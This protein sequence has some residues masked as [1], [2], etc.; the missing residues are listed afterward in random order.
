MRRQANV[1]ARV[2]A[3]YDFPVM[4]NGICGVLT[5]LNIFLVDQW[6]VLLYCPFGLREDEVDLV[7]GRKTLFSSRISSDGRADGQKNGGRRAPK[8]WHRDA[9]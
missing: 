3:F 5:N 2:Q 9:P 7:V 4:G 1:L 8:W 6:F